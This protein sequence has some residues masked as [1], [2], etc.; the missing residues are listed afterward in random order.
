M[1]RNLAAQLR[2]SARQ[3]NSGLRQAE[4]DIDDY[5]KSRNGPAKEADVEEIRN[6][7][8]AE[9]ADRPAEAVFWDTVGDYLTL[10]HSPR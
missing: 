1:D 8:I 3:P 10:Q 2:L 9:A 4:R 6:F 7:A 5:L